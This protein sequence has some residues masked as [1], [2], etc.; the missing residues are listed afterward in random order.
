MHFN[1][2]NFNFILRLNYC[3][4][5]WLNNWWENYQRSN[6]WIFSIFHCFL[7]TQCSCMGLTRRQQ[8]ATTIRY[9]YRTYFSCISI[10]LWGDCSFPK[11]MFYRNSSAHSFLSLFVWYVL[12]PFS[13]PLIGAM[14][15]YA[16][17]AGIKCD[18]ALNSI[19]SGLY[20]CVNLGMV[21]GSIFGGLI[22]Q[23]STFSWACMILV[24]VILVEAVVPGIFVFN[25]VDWTHG[26][27]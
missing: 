14:R 25:Q 15:K 17:D 12:D 21:T 20:G 19:I 18:F 22:L 23:Y 10:H 11:V 16:T 13:I 1:W 4:T 8:T 27:K 9:N 3:S 5:T 6:R 7:R 26:W 24:A 2:R